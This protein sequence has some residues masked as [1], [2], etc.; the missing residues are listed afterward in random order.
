MTAAHCRLA[1]FHGVRFKSGGRHHPRR[2][3][4][5]SQD[6]FTKCLPTNSFVVAIKWSSR[7]IALDDVAAW[8]FM[9]VAGLSRLEAGNHHEPSI[10]RR[11]PVPQPLVRPAHTDHAAWDTSPGTW[12][13][14]RGR[15]A[16]IVQ[17][18]LGPL[19]QTDAHVPTTVVSKPSRWVNCAMSSRMDSSRTCSS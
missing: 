10:A 14:A 2:P 6:G 12:L 7:A 18:E 5:Q 19:A 13:S 15:S 8:R 17:H 1:A 4:R 11:K 9:P 16:S 3:V